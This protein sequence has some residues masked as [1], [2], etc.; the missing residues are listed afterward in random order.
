MTEE[1]PALKSTCIEK[2]LHRKA[3][4]LKAL[5]LKKH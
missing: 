2:H 5:V 3:L 1:A 4:V